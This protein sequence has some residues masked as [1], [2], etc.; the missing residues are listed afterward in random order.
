MAEIAIIFSARQEW[1]A[2]RT[3]FPQM[4]P[5][6]GPYGE[7]FETELAGRRLALAHGGWGKIA[8]ASSAEYVLQRWR[9]SLLLNLGTCGGF[10]GHVE[11]GELIL[12]ERTVVYDIIEQMGDPQEAIRHYTCEIDLSWLKEPY[13][14]AVRRGVLVS[15][16]RDLL[17]VDIPK[18]TERYGAVAADWESGAIAWVA[19]RHATRC[20]ILR[21]VS[22]LVGAE[23]GEAYGKPEVF[24]QG[25]RSVIQGLLLHL[26][27]WLACA[28]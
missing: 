17:A 4:Q 6:M 15:A 24:A 19:A 8:A 7:W 21:G 3:F 11:R 18:L 9:P 25:T 10:A 28:D 13:P 2:A 23:G 27:Q 1:E 14:Q 5:Q 26:E 20:L 12:A 16:D 22:D